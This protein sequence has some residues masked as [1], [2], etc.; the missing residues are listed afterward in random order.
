MSSTGGS[1]VPDARSTFPEP[2]VAVVCGPT[3]AGKS[4]LA[5][6]F[7]SDVPVTIVSADSRQIYRGFDIGTAKPTA[8]EQAAVPH[9]GID[10]ADPTE[11]WSAWR[12]AQLAREAIASARAAGRVPLVVGGTGFYIRAL[13]APLAALPP[14]DERARGALAG[15][16]DRLS[17]DDLR[18]WCE[19]LDPARAPLGPV[20]WRRAIEVA[21]LTGTPI[22]TW[23]ARP[24]PRPALP[25][26]YL[27]VDPGAA[28]PHRIASRVRAMIEQGW[29]TEV[30]D[31][32]ARVPEAAPAWQ[33]TGYD[34]LRAVVRGDGTLGEAIGQVTVQTRQYAKRQRTWFRHQ[35]V[36]GAVE[37]V[38]PEDPV[39][40]ER[41]LAW[42]RAHCLETL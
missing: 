40:I 10:V 8:D 12:W 31:L 21:L 35:L 11:R 23:Y 9:V 7:A 25:V 17:L 36:E 24:T 14:L 37:R 19:R 5:M 3:A 20:Q 32:M 16:L 15:W 33:A 22:S 13:V 6:R 2:P 4:A 38:S 1:G 34:A 41:A 28:L 18:R 26:R 30:A 39:D 27:V 29:I 42:W